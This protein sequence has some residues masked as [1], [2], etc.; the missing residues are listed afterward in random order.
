MWGRMSR[1]TMLL[2]AASACGEADTPM[3]TAPERFCNGLCEAET[4]CGVSRDRASCEAL[5]L[6]SRPGLA[7]LS[8]QGAEPFANCI[9]GLDC[10]DLFTDEAFEACWDRAQTEVLP[11]QYVRSFCHEFASAF[12]ECGYSLSTD[13]CEGI[14]GMWAERVLDRVT[15]CLQEETCAGLEACSAG[16]FESL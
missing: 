15:P 7:S 4:R 10:I 13:E 6:E 16:V 12:Y 9:R 1:F 8:P 3:P 2:A 14:Y 5:C 11:T